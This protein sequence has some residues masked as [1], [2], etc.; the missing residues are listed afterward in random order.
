MTAHR[1]LDCSS[2]GNSLWVCDR[3][4]V[5]AYNV[6]SP[7]YY[8]RVDDRMYN[9]TARSLIPNDCDE[10]LLLRVLVG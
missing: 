10:E 1:W 5:K 6:G 8:R 4:R 3:C 2:Y 7:N 9:P